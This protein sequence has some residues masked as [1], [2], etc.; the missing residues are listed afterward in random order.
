MEKQ[1]KKKL[2]LGGSIFDYLR[3]P[4]ESTDLWTK[5]SEETMKKFGKNDLILREKFIY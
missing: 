3:L 2:K 5:A 4:D 1:K